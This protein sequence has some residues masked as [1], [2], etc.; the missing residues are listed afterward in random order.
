MK[1][2]VRKNVAIDRKIQTKLESG[3]LIFLKPDGL[4]KMAHQPHERENVSFV[5]GRLCNAFYF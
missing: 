4:S 3:S 1:V 2:Y 5:F